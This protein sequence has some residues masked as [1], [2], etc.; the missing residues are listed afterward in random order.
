MLVY[1]W[2]GSGSTACCLFAH[3]LVCI[4]QVDLE[5]VSDSSGA[6]L[7]SQC[8]VAWRSFVQAGGSGWVSEFCF[9]VV[10]VAPVSRQDF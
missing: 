7:V 10:F 9:L 4:S 2:G 1:P 8:N 5:L 6:L 3:L